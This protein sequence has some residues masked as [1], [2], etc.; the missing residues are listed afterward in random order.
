MK[1]LVAILVIF[2]S[3]TKA[4]KCITCENARSHAECDANGKTVTCR[5]NELSCAIEERTLNLGPE[6]LIFKHCKQPNACQNNEIQNPRPAWWP[7]QCNRKIPNT[8]CRCCCKEDLC[9]VGPDKCFNRISNECSPPHS[10]P[11]FGEVTCSKS[12]EIGSLCSFKCDDG[13]VMSGASTSTCGENGAWSSPAPSCA[14]IRCPRIGSS[15]ARSVDCSIDHVFIAN[16][17]FDDLT[18]AFAREISEHMCGD[19][20]DHVLHDHV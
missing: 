5:Y 7:T 4:L 17:G 11:R 14:S 20:C 12:N 9:N 1:H 10:N 13:Y 16:N 8:V 18:P 2:V 6:K 15:S 3:T 19:P